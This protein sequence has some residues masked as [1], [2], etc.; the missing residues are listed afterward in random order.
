M[1]D[2]AAE[3]PALNPGALIICG[4][5]KKQPHGLFG[6]IRGKQ[7]RWMELKIGTDSKPELVYYEHPKSTRSQEKGIVYLDG[8]VIETV[9]AHRAYELRIS[10]ASHAVGGGMGAAGERDDAK[11]VGDLLLEFQS[12]EVCA[13]WQ[14]ALRHSLSGNPDSSR[15]GIRQ[16][17]NE[18]YKNYGDVSPR[19][20]VSV[21]ASD[22]VRAA[23]AAVRASAASLVAAPPAPDAHPEATR[24]IYHLIRASGLRARDAHPEATQAVYDLIKASALKAVDKHPVATG[25]IL[26][27]IFH[28]KPRD[29]MVH[30]VMKV[31]VADKDINDFKEVVLLML[32]ATRAEEGCAT[33]PRAFV[34][35]CR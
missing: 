35:V 24:A 26:D 32:T 10:G 28:P 33:F 22:T 13:K 30:A 14:A 8:S 12:V 2:F 7:T 16:K 21:A 34:H 19:R 15:S 9:H 4:V 20:V 17:H 27:L 1:A 5:V 6:G 3:M 23:V 18:S 29:A 11:V 25:A 31:R